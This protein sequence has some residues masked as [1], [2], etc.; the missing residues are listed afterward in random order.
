MKKKKCTGK[1]S[2]M[3]FWDYKGTLSI[4]LFFLFFFFTVLPTFV[5]YLI[6][7]TIIDLT[8]LTLLDEN[9]TELDDDGIT[10]VCRTAL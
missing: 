2:N 5:L 4:V 10:V 7:N 9:L 3:S 8:A 1:K 6:F